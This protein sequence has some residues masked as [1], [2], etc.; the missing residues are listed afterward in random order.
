M[1]IPEASQQDKQTNR[2]KVSPAVSTAEGK[3]VLI[4]TLLGEG[5]FFF[6]FVLSK[7]KITTTT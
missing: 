1:N 6:C 3:T 5:V 7:K 4:F 2:L